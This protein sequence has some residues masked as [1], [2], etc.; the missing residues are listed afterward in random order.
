[1]YIHGSLL[2]KVWKIHDQRRKKF[3]IPFTAHKSDMTEAL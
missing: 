3:K 2:V 1:M